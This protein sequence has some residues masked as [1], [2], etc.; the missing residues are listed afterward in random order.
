MKRINRSEGPRLI[1]YVPAPFKREV[2]RT[3]NEQGISVSTLIQLALRD[4]LERK[5]RP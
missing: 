5:A 1:S 3:A 2:E 4:Y